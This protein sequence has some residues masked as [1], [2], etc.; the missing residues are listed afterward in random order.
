M[1]QAFF[2]IIEKKLGQMLIE[3]NVISPTQLKMA[4]DRQKTTNGKYIGEILGEMG[5]P[6]EK[7]NEA[8]DASGKRK[9]L[10]EILIDLGWLT[11]NELRQSLEKQ[12]HL[13]IRKPLGNL[14]LEMGYISYEVFQIALSR[15][16]VLPTISLKGFFP[17]RALQKAVGEAYAL[18][19]KIVVLENDFT[20]ISIAIAEPNAMIMDELRRGVPATKRVEF[21]L[22][23]PME[24]EYC[25]KQRVDPFVVSYYR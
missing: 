12:K 13:A 2:P 9:R 14:L 25:F 17:S 16:F 18:R 22:A 5:V 4:L 19:H 24:I 10:G 3:R 23:N 11:P 7:I 20:T 1:A 8:L 6:R 15:H 21:Y